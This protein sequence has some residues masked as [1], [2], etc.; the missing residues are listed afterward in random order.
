VE[1]V[2]K[3]R[4]GDPL[5]DSVDL[6]PVITAR[7]L[8]RF[9]EGLVEPSIAAGAKVAVGGTYD[10][11]FYQPTVLTDVTAEMPIFREETFGPVIPITVVDSRAAALDLANRH[12]TLMNSVFTGDPLRGIEFA[13]RIASNEV[14]IND[15]Y[16][17]HGGEGQLASF[18]RRQWI[19]VQTSPTSYPAWAQGN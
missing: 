12:R 3:L 9:H 17:R 5:R 6:G 10:G 4:V 2:R 15:G 14:H 1:R 16:A 11:L 19:G 7:Q 18:T 8:A 13:Q